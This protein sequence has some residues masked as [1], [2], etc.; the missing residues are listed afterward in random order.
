MEQEIFD[1]FSV[2]LNVSLTDTEWNDVVLF[3]NS[4]DSSSKR[5]TPPLQGQSKRVLKESYSSEPL[6]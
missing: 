2:N 1:W 6:K 3:V 4:I 5:L